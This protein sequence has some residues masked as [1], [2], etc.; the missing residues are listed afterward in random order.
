MTTVTAPPLQKLLTVTV[1]V[2]GLVKLLTFSA[3]ICLSKYL[4][5][6]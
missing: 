3:H 6:F 1:T 4:V 2:N 5:A